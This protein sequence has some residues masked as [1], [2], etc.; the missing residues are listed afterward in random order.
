MTD[1]NNASNASTPEDGPAVQISISFMWDERTELTVDETP[2]VLWDQHVNPSRCIV[3]IHEHDFVCRR[4]PLL[5]LA[6]KGKLPSKVETFVALWL[7][8][9][10]QHTAV[11][12]LVTCPVGVLF[13]KA[14]P[15]VVQEIY[16]DRM[17]YIAQLAGQRAYSGREPAP[18][19]KESM[20]TLQGCN[21]EE[22]N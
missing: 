21:Y 8:S 5:V 17:A 22:G 15:A 16:V 13:V 11:H 1:T 7:H 18:V 20:P 19:P 14:A 12:W 10:E 3:G 6:A 9:V 4:M 2:L